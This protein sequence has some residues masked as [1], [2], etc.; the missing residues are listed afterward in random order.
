VNGMTRRTFLKH[1]A[2]GAWALASPVSLRGRLA[3]VQPAAERLDQVLEPVR[4]AHGVPALAGAFIRGT[5]G[6][7][8]LHVV[9]FQTVARDE[10][11]ALASLTVVS[12]AIY[13]LHPPVPGIG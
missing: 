7:S 10:A 3:W 8:L 4:S 12:D 5:V 6:R 1:M 13:E 2:A 11:S 9:E